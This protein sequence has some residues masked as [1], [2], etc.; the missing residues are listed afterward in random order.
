MLNVAYSSLSDEIRN[1]P[2]GYIIYQNG[3]R[4]TEGS[5]SGYK[6]AVARGVRLGIGTDAGLIRHAAVWKELR[7]FTQHAELSNSE[8][9]HIAT[10]ATAQSIGVEDITGSIEAGKSADLIVLERD[11]REDLSALEHPSMVLADGVIAFP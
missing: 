5:L 2:Q 6:T 4:I 7:Y 3:K 11:P 1:D 9:L 8:V 10:L